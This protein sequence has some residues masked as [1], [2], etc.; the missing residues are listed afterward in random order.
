MDFNYSKFFLWFHSIFIIGRT[1]SFIN[2]WFFSFLIINWIWILKFWISTLN[3][4]ILYKFMRLLFLITELILIRYKWMNSLALNLR[5][6]IR[7]FEYKNIGVVL[8]IERVD[9]RYCLCLP[10]D[11]FLWVG[12]SFHICLCNITIGS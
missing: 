5:I 7:L 3:F 9:W 10:S 8:L 12:L 2:F 4:V 1:T 11:T 6:I